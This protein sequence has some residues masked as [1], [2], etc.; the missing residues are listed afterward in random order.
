MNKLLMQNVS[1]IFL[2]WFQFAKAH[3]AKASFFSMLC[4]VY[5]I[6]NNILIK[7]FGDLVQSR[8]QAVCEVEALEMLNFGESQAV[9]TFP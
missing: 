9:W 1:F 4:N 6:I 3:S 2:P 5:A 8:I 7:D